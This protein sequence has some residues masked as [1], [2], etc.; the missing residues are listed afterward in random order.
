M[1]TKASSAKIQLLELMP[2]VCFYITY[3]NSDLIKAT[4]G[5][6]L[7]SLVVIFINKVF[8]KKNSKLVYFTTAVLVAFGGLTIFSG[9]VTFIKMNP[10]ILY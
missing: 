5:L 8:F 3:L 7:A 1:K 9:D 10:T 4:I 6:I 2:P